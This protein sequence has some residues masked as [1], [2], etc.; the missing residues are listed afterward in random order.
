MSDT[1]KKMIRG[2]VIMLLAV[3][4]IF[5]GIFGF[6][7]F[8]TM[9]IKKFMANQKMPPVTVTAMQAGF[10]EWQ[11]QIRVAGSLR[12]VQGVDVTCEA[13]GLVRAVNFQP[14]QQVR[15]GE[16]LVELNADSDMAQ[17]RS[18]EAAVALAEIVYER[19]VKQ[20]AARA[21]SKAVLDA[22]EADLK[23][24]K[25]ALDQQKALLEKKLI[26][27]PF[28]GRLGISTVNLGQYLEPGNKVVTLQAL[29]RLYGDF[30]IPQQDIGRIK[31]GQVVIA[32]NDTYPGRTF[33]GKISAINPKVEPES[34]NIQV[35]SLIS[36]SGHDLL[37]GMFVSIDVQ[38]GASEKRLTLP[39]TAVSFNPYGEMVF[40]VQRGPRD[41]SGREAL[42][43]KQSLVTVG[44]ARGDQVSI[45]SGVK[46]GDIV[47]TSGHFKLKPG[48]AVVID[49]K[50][51]PKNDAA[52]MPVDE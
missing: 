48:S 36:N 40:I 28:A 15:A 1:K 30:Y 47:V 14:G 38:T 2:M 17:L 35:E 7:A 27:A 10:E 37:P 26:R 13:A 5:G 11:P 22:D 3:G 52:P 29:D 50:V 19:D 32:T 33:R 31:K 4:I 21:I 41:A 24:K 51:V 46:E 49:N 42:T 8:Q 25:A 23:I 9:M 39:Q 43:V 16:I 45:V 44:P 18:F 20:F 6:K 34:R 12:A